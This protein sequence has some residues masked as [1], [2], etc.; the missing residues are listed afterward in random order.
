MFQ[1]YYELLRLARKETVY[2]TSAGFI[3]RLA[4]VMVWC[5]VAFAALLLPLGRPGC[6]FI[7]RRN[8]PVRLP[9]CARA[10]FS[11]PRRA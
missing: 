1:P 10:I 2:S 6:G 5:T 3:S 4:P 8:H 9:A 11:N 7:S